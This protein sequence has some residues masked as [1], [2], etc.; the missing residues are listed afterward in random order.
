DR[1]S[2]IRSGRRCRRRS[3]VME[4]GVAY[5]YIC[6]P[7]DCCHLHDTLAG[8]VSTVFC[9]RSTISSDCVCDPLGS[10]AQHESTVFPFQP[11]PVCASDC[12]CATRYRRISG[13]MRWDLQEL[14]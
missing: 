1:T 4:T 3:D 11:Y 9:P 14:S 10:T 5:S 2:I 7:Y 12:G 13:V 6:F 8:P